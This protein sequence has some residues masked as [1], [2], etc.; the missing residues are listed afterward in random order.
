AAASVNTGV[1]LGNSAVANNDNDVALGAGSSTAAPSTGP[2]TIN[3]GTVAA[4][5]DTNGVVSVGAA[6]KERQIQNVAAGTVSQT[7]TDAVNG[8]QLY[9]VGT[10]VNTNTTNIA[11]LQADQIHY[12]DVNDGGTAGGNFNNDGATGT[13][14][15]AAGVNVAATGD[16]SLAVGAD[17]TAT[18]VNS[19]AIGSGNDIV[20]GSNSVYVGIGN[21][22]AT[23]SSTND[24]AG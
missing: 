8:S 11:T 1:A 7:S 19:V 24:K 12:Y 20:N 23:G 22:T 13:N 14:A 3:G 5:T 17:N 2:Y 4:T 10:Q 9:A 6:G 16:S 15:L 18:G 21:R